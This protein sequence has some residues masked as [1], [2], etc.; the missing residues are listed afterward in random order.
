MQVTSES[1]DFV[2]SY[3]KDLLSSLVFQVNVKL[4]SLK[5]QKL[6]IPILNSKY[7]SN[8]KV[9]LVN[10]YLSHGCRAGCPR[11]SAVLP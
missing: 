3:V 1:A 7:H 5:W 10:A 6:K 11:R 4:T 8:Y 2:Q 9:Q